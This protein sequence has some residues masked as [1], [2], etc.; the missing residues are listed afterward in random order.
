MFGLGGLVTILIVLLL[1]YCSL[2]GFWVGDWICCV[3]VCYLLLMFA[4]TWVCCYFCCL[5]LFVCFGCLCW[6][7]LIC[8]FVGLVNSVGIV[9]YLV[10]MVCVS[11]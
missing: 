7:L 3:C 1:L 10:F 6:F 11:V 5:C 9:V 4:L 8:C 2:R